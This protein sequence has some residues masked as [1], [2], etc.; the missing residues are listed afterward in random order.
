MVLPFFGLMFPCFAAFIYTQ[1]R[2]GRRRRPRFPV[3]PGWR[4]WLCGAL[5]IGYAA[6]F[7]IAFG[8]NLGTPEQIG[9]RYYDD[10]HGTVTE[11]THARDLQ[12]NAMVSRL[13]AGGVVLFVA[14][15]DPGA[16]RG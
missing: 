4:R 5:F 2:F 8:S 9:G 11:I 14:L 10:N 15:D 1:G 3:P 16:D 7:L 13:F 12:E 6:G